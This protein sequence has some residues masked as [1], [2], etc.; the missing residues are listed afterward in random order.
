[1]RLA[2]SVLLYKSVCNATDQT[3][4]KIPAD[5]NPIFIT[6]RQSVRIKTP[7]RASDTV[8]TQEY[9]LVPVFEK[10]LTGLCVVRGTPA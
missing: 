10:F 6:V 4:V 9:E 7:P 3:P 1:M 5:H 2:C 8:R